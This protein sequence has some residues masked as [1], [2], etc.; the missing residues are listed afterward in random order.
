VVYKEDEVLLAACG[1]VRAWSLSSYATSVSIRRHRRRR[2]H[3]RVA[4]PN[5]LLCS[6]IC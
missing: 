1:C 3:R 6:V 4:L 5:P 2:R